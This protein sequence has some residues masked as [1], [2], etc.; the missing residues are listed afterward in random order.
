MGSTW[1][2]VYLWFA[3]RL[4]RV[5]TFPPCSHHWPPPPTF[6]YPAVTG[7]HAVT[8]LPPQRV[9]PTLQQH[10]LAR[11]PAP[12][13]PPTTPAL[14]FGTVC[15]RYR[16]R[17]PLLPTPAFTPRAPHPFPAFGTLFWYSSPLR[18]ALLHTHTRTTFTPPHPTTALF[19]QYLTFIALCACSSCTI[20][21]LILPSL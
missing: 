20:A 9:L 2:T 16:P 5:G 1:T 3:L 19:S 11:P 21:L 17:T 15:L 12:P 8:A 13:P 14:Q 4:G 6:P 7:P 10:G 18:S